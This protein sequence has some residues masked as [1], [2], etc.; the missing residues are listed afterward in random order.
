[1]E[2]KYNLLNGRARRIDKSDLGLMIIFKDGLLFGRLMIIEL[3]P[4]VFV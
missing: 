4:L 3:G 1:M 2:E